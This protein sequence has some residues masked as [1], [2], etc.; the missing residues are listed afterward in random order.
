MLQPGRVRHL[1]PTILLLVIALVAAACVNQGFD[2]E[3]G[4]GDDELT[5]AAPTEQG[6]ADETD[7]GGMD[8]EPVA[9]ETDGETDT[10][11]LPVGAVADPAS[12]ASIEMV[13]C[14]FD[15]PVPLPQAP[16]CYDVSVPEDWADPDTDD[17]VVLPV[18]VFAAD[19]GVEAADATIYL[20]GGPGA[21]TLD[22]LWTG[23]GSLHEPQTGPRD[24]VVFDQRGVGLSEP[25]LACPELDEV[26]LAEIA[27]E[28][29][30]GTEG[31]V[32]L[33]ATADCRDRLV[34]A[35]VNL[36]AYNS[37][38]SANDVEAIR[39]LLGYDQL[40]LLGI[41]YGTR[42]AQ[43]YVRQYPDSVRSMVLD[44]IVPV[45]ADLWS[46][47][48]RE[49][50]GAYEQLFLGCATDAACGEA[51]PDL[52]TRFFAL[53]D[54]LDAEPIEVEYRDLIQGTTVPA[55]VDGDD[56]LGLVFQAL[57]DRSAFSLIPGMVGEVESG[58]YATVEFLGSIGVT[59]LPFSSS[60]MQLAVECNEEIAFESAADLEANAPTDPG[61]ERLGELDGDATLF[62][63]CEV[64]ASGSAPDVEAEP[65]VTDVP[66]LL[67]AGA[68]DPITRPGNS[69]VV[70]ANL[71][72][73][74]S[75]L[76]PD[77]GH[78]IAPT[79]CG[80]E[81]VAA[82]LADPTVEPDSSCIAAAPRPAWVE[83]ADGASIQLVEFTVDSPFQVS[84][85]RPDG[86]EGAGAGVFAR[87]R[88][89]IDQTSL[90]VQP[91]S[92]ADPQ[93]LVE[94]IQGQLEVTFEPAGTLDVDGREWQTFESDDD[95]DQ[96][97]RLAAS[98]GADGILVVLVATAEEVDQL[99]DEVFLPVIESAGLG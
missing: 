91:T 38:A 37:V 52:E 80:A 44:S 48:A 34:R 71:G 28:L 51:N 12:L 15:E 60:G 96:V 89:A 1:R 95:P 77:E 31:D 58:D 35:G 49:A 7:S 97:V 20:D 47:L 66:A 82:F 92:G 76:F 98:T 40:N 25:S 46:N 8:D 9:D 59:N 16:S 21:S 4:L 69:D 45:E 53:L 32:V 72:N 68:Y 81:L 70:A 85:L 30:P 83:G 55:V 24:Y 74:F 2:D 50:R 42:L 36:E 79:E 23:F 41:S 33:A 99:V 67:L 19:D 73:H 93:F 87:Q 57:Y 56:L 6:D 88:T 18:A 65:V 13:P 26:E 22:L 86:W 75:F 84:G 11:D 5:E 17:R 63:I 61:Y 43:S 90:V 78:G 39:S 14:A 10:S 64:F 94:L 3:P 27:G 54:Q 62:D 29:D